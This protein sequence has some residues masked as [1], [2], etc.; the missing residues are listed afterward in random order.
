[1]SN[2]GTHNFAP[3]SGSRRSGREYGGYDNA[4]NNRDYS[5]TPSF[6]HFVPSQPLPAGDR[7]TQNTWR[8]I[9]ERVMA[10]PLGLASFNVQRHYSPT[11]IVAARLTRESLPRLLGQT[12]EAPAPAPAPAPAEA[13]RLTQDERNS[14][15]KKLKKEI[16]NPIPKSITRRLSLYY[17]D[18]ALDVLKE[19][20]KEQEDDGKRCAVCLEDFEPKEQV[21]LTPCN[22][23]FHEDCIVPW[24]KSNGQ[25]PVCRFALSGAGGRP[26][27]PPV[28][29]I[30]TNF[31]TEEDVLQGELI[32][33]LRAME[34]AFVRGNTA[35]W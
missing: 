10:G 32:S 5:L 24:V 6:P 12:T 14:A 15:L 19:R 20:A 27:A 16:Y 34:E 9:E 33:V 35:R 13:S 11:Q 25:C 8:V 26:S 2:G 3:R 18:R 30:T 4:Y 23:M 22:H 29:A 28:P 21:M 17:R 1:M 7:G 31:A